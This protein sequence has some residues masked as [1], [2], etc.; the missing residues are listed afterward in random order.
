MLLPVTPATL[1]KRVPA[2]SDKVQVTLHFYYGFRGDK[3]STGEDRL[4]S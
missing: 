1:T 2:K 3:I 4:I